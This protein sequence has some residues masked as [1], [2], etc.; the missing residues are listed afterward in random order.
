MFF[1]MLLVKF[2]LMLC[3]LTTQLC[4]H[5]PGSTRLC[6]FFYRH[7]VGGDALN[8]VGDSAVNVVAKVMSGFLGKSPAAGRI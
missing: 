8:H 4:T 3:W 5:V 7:L 6:Q 1:F 2:M